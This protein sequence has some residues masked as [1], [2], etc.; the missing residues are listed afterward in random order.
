[1]KA[2][3]CYYLSSQQPL[4]EAMIKP[5]L[6]EVVGHK[7]QLQFVQPQQR[8]FLLP[9]DH[10]D[11]LQS[12]LSSYSQEHHEKLHILITY[13]SHRLGEIAS[14]VGLKHNQGKVDHLADLLIQLMVEH[15]PI[16][17]PY[18]RE[19]FK[20][21]PR[22]LVL[23]ATMLMQCGMNA[24]LAAQ[25]LYLHRNT[26]SYRLNQFINLTGLNIRDH[27]HALFFNLAQ[28]LVMQPD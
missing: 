13:R 2:A 21:I 12:F 16:L 7:V 23:T 17:I 28:R 14:L 6:E 10:R 27:N 19:E 22:H 5:W 4:K 11:T 15:N 9:T 24:S 26:F 25:K 8:W 20:A 18:I 1:M 3:Y